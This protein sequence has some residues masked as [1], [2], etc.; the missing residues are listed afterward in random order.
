MSLQYLTS[1][2]Q[3]RSIVGTKECIES[4]SPGGMDHLDRNT[5]QSGRKFW[6]IY[7]NEA[8]RHDKILTDTWKADMDSTLIFAGLFSATIT[9]FIIESYKQLSQDSGDLTASLLQD[10]LAVQ[11]AA[12]QAA[13]NR[14]VSLPVLK[15]GSNFIPA[16]TSVAVNI[17]W[18]LSLACSLGAALCIILVQEW[19]RDYLQRVQR[20]SQPHRR[21]RFRGVLFSGIQRWKFE[22]VVEVVPTMLHLSLFLFFIGLCIFIGTINRAVMSAIV[23]VVILC[24]AFYCFATL[25]PLLD[26][27]SPYQTVISSIMWRLLQN[28]HWRH[29]H[30][31][32]GPPNPVTTDLAMARA[33]M[34][35]KPS[36]VA[37]SALSNREA[38]HWVLRETVDDQELEN[39]AASIPG[40]LSGHPGIIFWYQAFSSPDDRELLCNQIIS[41]LDNSPPNANSY[42]DLETRTRRINIGVDALRALADPPLHSDGYSLSGVE[43]TIRFA[44]ERTIK[45]WSSDTYIP[46]RCLCILALHQG[47]NLGFTL[48]SQT[49]EKSHPDMET[50]T[51]RADAALEAVNEL[52]EVIEGVV[53][54]IKTEPHAPAD[55]WMFLQVY[56]GVLK[57][58]SNHLSEIMNVVEQLLKKERSPYHFPLMSWYSTLPSAGFRIVFRDLGS[59]SRVLEL[60][61]YAL[62]VF[63]HLRRD[64]KDA[65][66]NLPSSTWF[67]LKQAMD[68]SSLNQG[69]LAEYQAEQYIMNYAPNPQDIEPISSLLDKLYPLLTPD[70]CII[71]AYLKDGFHKSVFSI[72]GAYPQRG[73]SLFDMLPSLTQIGPFRILM[74]IQ[75]DFTKQ[76]GRMCSLLEFVYE[77][78]RLGHGIGL[79]L[80]ASVINDILGSLWKVT[81]IGRTSRGSQILF[82]CA[83][84]EILRWEQEATVPGSM[85][86]LIPSETIDSIIAYFPIYVRW[87]EGVE[88]AEH[89][90]GRIGNKGGDIGLSDGVN[91]LNS[92]KEAEK[93]IKGDHQDLVKRCNKVYAHIARQRKMWQRVQKS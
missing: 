47:L 21:A 85:P 49:I 16:R 57:S 26:P 43:R 90:L 7:V 46:T 12:A 34:A 65:N 78:R 86:C 93:F 9:A 24:L 5:L 35:G 67:P 27:A 56:F 89:V 28:T 55:I 87:K 68:M 13:P 88:M 79:P 75:E 45:A 73:Y 20:Y 22:N 64:G 4:L 1:N 61:L 39:L 19:I 91:G 31:G 14:N 58:S 36:R 44:L 83:V 41:L 74:C 53:K 52:R 51:M 8:E 80:Q 82:V 2:A 37:D 15:S 29:M 10:L 17:L 63:A 11:I 6:T 54:G 40:L 18:F 62:Q 92:N 38:V 76:N 69:P 33:D 70:T 48:A 81:E 50:L 42:V 71:D 32:G 23:V 3:Q 30:N 66:L 77:A 84:Q 59:K 25:A 72:P 60:P